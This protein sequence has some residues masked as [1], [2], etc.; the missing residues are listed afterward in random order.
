MNIYEQLDSSHLCGRR[1]E[2]FRA[3][4]ESV[5]RSLGSETILLSNQY[6]EVPVGSIVLN[7]P[8]LASPHDPGF[9]LVMGTTILHRLKIGCNTIG[10]FTDNDIIIRDVDRMVSRRHCTII[11]HTDGSAEMFDTSLN[12]TFVNETRINRCQIRSGDRLRLGPYISFSIVLY[13]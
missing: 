9:V 2:R 11:V 7:R 3:V 10:R 4:R 12:G 8:E 1:L 13:N 5:A 6:P